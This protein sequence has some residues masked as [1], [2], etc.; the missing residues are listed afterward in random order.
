M[1]DANWLRRKPLFVALDLLKA[2]KNAVITEPYVL[3]DT[4]FCSPVP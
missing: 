1:S 2:A 4:W 3:F